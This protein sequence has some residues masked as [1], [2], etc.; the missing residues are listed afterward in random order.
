MSYAQRYAPK[1][2]SDIKGQEEA[3]KQIKT[4]L[5]LFPKTKHKA[6][7]LYGPS[8]TGK[9]SS[10]IA[11]AQELDL[12]LIETNA[13]DV[14]NK[15]QIHATIGAAL[16]Q[17]SLF[18][19]KKILLIDEVDGISGQ[20][21]RGGMN[22]LVELITGSKNFIIL[23]CT[24]PYDNSFSNL[25]KLC[26]LVPFEKLSTQILA[27][28]L[29]EIC[30][31]E[32]IAYDESAI[33]QLARQSGGDMR[34]ALNDLH[35]LSSKKKITAETL[36]DLGF[37]EQQDTMPNAL[38]KI[39]KTTDLSVAVQAFERIEEDQDEQFLWLDKNIPLEYT[40]PQDL[41]RAY[42]SLALADMYRGRI[43]RWQHWR[44]MVYI[45]SFLTAGVAGAKDEKNST[46]VKYTPT[47][48]LLKIWWAN[49]K[50]EKKK[51][52]AKKIAPLLH[53]SS[54]RAAQSAIPMLQQV[55]RNN[56]EKSEQIT[57]HFDFDEE[58]I[59]WLR[60]E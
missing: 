21:D 16:K 42:E 43:R 17:G 45:N 24:D 14:R 41:A 11:A 27:D 25:R 32:H 8:G 47:G 60:G 6:L 39:F 57:K 31:K 46:F 18:G 26:M 13:S 40:K 55:Y 9:T 48:R 28:Q 23:T 36:E 20:S 10:V 44:F 7:L 54:K 59:A 35:I 22:A 12:E 5:E 33:K 15:D 56:K 50:Q 30:E 4:Y 58:E 53:T 1:Q 34:A 38:T 2:L 52:I 29:K 51:A 37:R 3:I 49:R 19:R